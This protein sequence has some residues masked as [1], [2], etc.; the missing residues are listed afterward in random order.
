MFVLLETRGKLLLLT[1][2]NWFV[3]MDYCI[4]VYSGAPI[5]LTH[6]LSYGFSM[7]KTSY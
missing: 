7:G 3:V 4:L 6:Y 2:F 1:A 5:L